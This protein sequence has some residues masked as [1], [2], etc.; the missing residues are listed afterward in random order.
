MP[1]PRLASRY[2]KSLLDLAVEQKQLDAT[3]KDIELLHSISKQSRDFTN[4]LRSPIIKADKKHTIINAV[5]GDNISALS[6]AFINLLVTKGRE[7]NLPE[8]A[9]AFISQYKVLNNIKT[10]KLTTATPVS[11][12]VKQAIHNKVLASMPANV[13]VE[14][15]EEVNPELIG[16]FV[17][18]MDDKLFDASIRRDLNDVK[19]QFLK[20]MYIS[21]FN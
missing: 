7:A 17:L 5:I 13:K 6:K 8:I 14:L 10:V 2:A 20:N 12:A 3:L 1:N 11:D 4:M 9:E 18:Q 19:A 21:N 16:G 15:K